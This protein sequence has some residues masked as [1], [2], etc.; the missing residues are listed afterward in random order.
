MVI[1][2]IGPTLGVVRVKQDDGTFTINYNKLKE[3]KGEGG[4]AEVEEL[5]N[6][7]VQNIISDTYVQPGQTGLDLI[8]SIN[9]NI[10]IAKVNAEQLVK[11]PTEVI[12]DGANN[13]E[14]PASTIVE[15]ERKKAEEANMGLR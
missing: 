4:A 11:G 1:E 9:N 13:E 3:L 12:K 8:E 10:D 2:S 6:N 7:T 14:E 15:E 5:I